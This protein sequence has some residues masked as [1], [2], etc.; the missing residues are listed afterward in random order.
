MLITGKILAFDLAT[1]TGW[2]CGAPEDLPTF[3]THNFPSTGDNIGRHQSNARA[4]F[5]QMLNAHRPAYVIFEQPSLF[6]KTTP[7]TMRKLCALANTLEEVCLEQKIK[8]E[9]GNPKRVKKFWTGNGN[10]DKAMM[11]RFARRYGFKVHNDDEADAIAHWFYAVECHGAAEHKTRFHQMRFE[12]GLTPDAS[13]IP[14]QT[15]A[16]F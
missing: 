3:G 2:A 6:G 4:W 14:E 11:F 5:N 13:L 7:T 9:Q 8:C 15:T 1:Q 16:G 12:A 10:A